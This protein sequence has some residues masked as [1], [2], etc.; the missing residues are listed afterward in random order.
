[1]EKKGGKTKIQHLQRKMGRRWRYGFL[2]R[3]GR[4]EEGQLMRGQMFPMKNM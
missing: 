3:M 2:E 1:M 4:K